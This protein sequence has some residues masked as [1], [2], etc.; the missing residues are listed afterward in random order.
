M[1]IVLNALYDCSSSPPK[2][3]FEYRKRT[4]LAT[5]SHIKKALRV[6]GAIVVG[7]IVKANFVGNSLEAP[8]EMSHS[9]AQQGQAAAA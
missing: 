6:R 2:S 1:C 8:R 4:L 3:K 5:E 9:T 7:A